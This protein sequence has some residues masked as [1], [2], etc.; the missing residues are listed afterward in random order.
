MTRN[1]TTNC[2]EFLP[3]EVTVKNDPN[4]EDRSTTRI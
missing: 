1:I 4:Y 2:K 3:K